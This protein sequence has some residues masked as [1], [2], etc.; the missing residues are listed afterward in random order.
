MH[1]I[2]WASRTGIVH[3][4]GRSYCTVQGTDWATQI[5]DLYRK[6][7]VSYPST[8]HNVRYCKHRQIHRTLI[9]SGGRWAGPPIPRLV[10]N[11]RANSERAEWHQPTY[12]TPIS[13]STPKK[14]RVVFSVQISQAQFCIPITFRPSCY[15]S[16]LCLIWSPNEYFV[17]SINYEAP[18]YTGP[19]HSI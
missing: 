3:G 10:W 14:T 2:F 1:C 16:C 9:N 11:T 19:A 18:H 4:N 8:L 12:D 6:V 5:P 17:R 13:R 15:V 7:N